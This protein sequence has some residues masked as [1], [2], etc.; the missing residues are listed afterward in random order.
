M[1]NY[2]ANQI[3]TLSTDSPCSRQGEC[4]LVFS[5]WIILKIIT[6]RSGSWMLVIASDKV[7]V[8]NIKMR[9]NSTILKIDID[10]LSLPS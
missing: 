1:D 2:V 4:L 10:N 5:E 7:V 3:N 9:D 6:K 8:V